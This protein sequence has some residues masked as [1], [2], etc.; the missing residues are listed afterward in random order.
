[1]SSRRLLLPVTALAIVLLPQAPVHAD[2][3]S[4]VV[5]RA[6]V[7]NTAE[8]CSLARPAGEVPAVE[9]NASP[10]GVGR[11]PGVR[12]GGAIET[13]AGLCT[14]NFLFSGS[15]GRRYIGTSAQ[16]MKPF[17]GERAPDPGRREMARDRTGRRIGEFAY[18]VYAGSADFALIALDS[19]VQASPQMCHFGGPTGLNA[20]SRRAPV[21][22]HYYGNGLV[23]A[24]T[25][26]LPM[27]S[28][29]G[30]VTPGRSAVAPH[31]QNPVWVMAVGTAIYGDL[32][33]GVISDDGR[34]VGLVVYSGFTT[35]SAGDSAGTLG[36]IRL[37]PQINR[38]EKR[39]GIKLRL[40]VDPER[41]PGLG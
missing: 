33:S 34:A 24:P 36:I 40:E 32:G 23:P 6:G 17:I 37:G 7:G 8:S 39:L 19:L 25:S 4:A 20:D 2:P 10:V 14:L 30:P 26:A 29:V 9:V 21:V 27:R 35:T 38:A 15:D 12:P 13:D 22:L 41:T 5:P 16:C 3:V 11:C 18:G 31:L 1:M 28:G